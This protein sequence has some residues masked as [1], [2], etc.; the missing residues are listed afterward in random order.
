[1]KSHLFDMK[2]S[3]VA[4]YL[5]LR[6]AKE[7]GQTFNK[8]EALAHYAHMHTVTACRAL[9]QLKRAGFVDYQPRRLHELTLKNA[10]TY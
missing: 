10:A 8:L 6:L 1:M 9:Q 7:Q 5:A 2:P 3:A 4:L